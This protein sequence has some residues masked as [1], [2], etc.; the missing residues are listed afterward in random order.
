VNDGILD[1]PE[2]RTSLILLCYSLH[3]HY[4]QFSPYFDAEDAWDPD[5]EDGNYSDE[6]GEAINFSIGALALR[7]SVDELPVARIQAA[8]TF[9]ET[10]K[11]VYKERFKAFYHLALHYK[12]GE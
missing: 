6:V 4:S 12:E 8:N 11:K 1:T 9:L 3:E 10:L 7:D 2:E 5:L